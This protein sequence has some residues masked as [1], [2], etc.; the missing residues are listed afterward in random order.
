[1]TAA[2]VPG[3][4]LAPACTL[5]LLAILSFLYLNSVVY[6][7]YTVHLYLFMQSHSMT[8]KLA[9]L[10]FKGHGSG[11]TAGRLLIRRSV[12]GSLDPS[13]CVSQCPRA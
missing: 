2:V 1:M 4:T 12:V 11:V 8:Y 13:L 5:L 7:I 10:H 3:L 6:P 9:F